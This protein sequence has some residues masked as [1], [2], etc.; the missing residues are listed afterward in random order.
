MIF[1]IETLLTVIV[2]IAAVVSYK[3][4]NVHGSAFFSNAVFCSDIVSSTGEPSFEVCSIASYTSPSPALFENGTVIYMG[5]YSAEYVI[6]K[7]IAEGTEVTDDPKQFAGIGISVSRDDF[8]KCTVLVQYADSSMDKEC[9][10]C[11][12]CGDESYSVDCSNV[13]FGRKL[14]VCES[15]LPDVV[16]FPLTADALLNQTI[17]TIEV[18]NNNTMQTTGG[19]GGKPPK[20]QMGGG[21]PKPAGVMNGGGKPQM[22]VK[23]GGKNKANGGVMKTNVKP[24]MI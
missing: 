10:G 15:T 6:T 21:K 8:D 4:V 3:S 14:E 12:Y 22:N 23:G 17:P 7:G 11:K 5:G 2:T 9:S 18:P 24:N 19:G 16:F 20:Q 1:T 13:D